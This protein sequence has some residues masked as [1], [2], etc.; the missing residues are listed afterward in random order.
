[1]KYLEIALCLL[2]LLPAAG[3]DR[4]DE[5]ESPAAFDPSVDGPFASVDLNADPD[6]LADQGA[7]ARRAGGEGRSEPAPST[8]APAAPGAEEPQPRPAAQPTPPAPE[9]AP[10]GPGTPPAPG[11]P[12]EPTAPG[13]PVQGPVAEEVRAA[14]TEFLQ[15][16]RQGDY[17]RIYP[18]L[19]D[20]SAEMLRQ[21]VEKQEETNALYQQFSQFAQQQLGR[22]IERE[23]FFDELQGPVVGEDSSRLRTDRMEV[24]R[25][26]E[27]MQ[28]A[29][30][31]GR[32][33]LQFVRADGQWKRTFGPIERRQLEVDLLSLQVAERMMELTRE[34]IS[35]GQITRQNVGNEI[36]TLM[37][38]YRLPVQEQRNSIR[39]AP[40]PGPQR[41][42]VPPVPGGPNAPPRR[43]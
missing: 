19:T 23:S 6:L 28:L 14:A 32:P 34:G 43:P 12:P 33:M 18:L 17:E 9:A 29:D 21:V 7:L 13:T 2:V 31:R 38:E 39:S 42:G 36:T 5:S 22:S 3:C 25:Q 11:G 40:S 15:T 10:P 30:T 35:D 27:T 8:A 37:I 16:A 41:P 1:M 26:G 20:E 4:Q 24:L